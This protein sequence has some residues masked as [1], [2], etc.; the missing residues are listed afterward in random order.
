MFFLSFDRYIRYLDQGIL[1]ISFII[2]DLRY[3]LKWKGKGESP[4]RGNIP[5][6]EGGYSTNV[7]MNVNKIPSYRGFS[8][9][10]C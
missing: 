9:S 6:E 7:T 4:T 3:C 1:V 10:W 5:T 8:K 2:R